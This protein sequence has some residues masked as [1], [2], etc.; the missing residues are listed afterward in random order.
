MGRQGLRA[1]HW[2]A[3][4]KEGGAAAGE[5][6]PRGWGR[7]DPRP[8]L[9]SASRHPPRT[10]A[11]HRRRGKRGRARNGATSHFPVERKGPS[12]APFRSSGTSVSAINPPNFHGRSFP[13]S[14][15]PFFMWLPS[16]N[17][18]VSRKGANTTFF[19]SE[20]RTAQP[21]AE[22]AA[23]CSRGPASR[24][25]LRRGRRAWGPP[26]GAQPR[27]PASARGLRA[28]AVGPRTAA[29][30]QVTEP[31][32]EAWTQDPGPRTQTRTRS[33]DPGPQTQ[34]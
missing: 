5:Q 9:R 19:R 16:P 28:P 25:A 27:G 13:I 24:P 4:W 23:L 10:R 8:G 22:P 17:F 15:S 33:L 18:K 32:P 11:S 20:G 1:I 3:G 14:L 7:S 12:V 30:T 31:E 21:A 2:G 26:R 34:A 6:E 29:C